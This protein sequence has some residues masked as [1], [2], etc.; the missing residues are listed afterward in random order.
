MKQKS[1][2]KLTI[3]LYVFIA[4]AKAAHT[5]YYDELGV[6]TKAS[7][8]EIRKAYRKLAKK[9]HPDKNPDPSAAERFTKVA[10]G[11]VLIV[12]CLM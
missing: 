5:E 11:K 8:N 12:V 2:F 4:L 10:N 9:Y 6:D 3:T 7:A 1:L